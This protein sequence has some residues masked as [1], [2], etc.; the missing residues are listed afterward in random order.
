MWRSSSSLSIYY[1]DNEGVYPPNLEALIPQHLAAIPQPRINGHLTTGMQLYGA[2]VCLPT[3]GRFD[4]SLD[5]TKLRDSGKWGYV[6]AP[7]SP[8]DRSVFV[9]CTHTDSKGKAWHSY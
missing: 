8:C 1:G 9:D 7:K 2:E 5:P 4:G 3:T 6:S